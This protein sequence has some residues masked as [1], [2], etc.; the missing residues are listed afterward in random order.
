MNKIAHLLTISLAIILVCDFLGC[1]E[2]TKQNSNSL[3]IGLSSR[4]KSLDPRISTDVSSA[5]VQQLVFNSLVKKDEK[6]NIIPDLAERWEIEDN[7][8]YRFFLRKKVRFHNGKLLT[9]KDVKAT[10]EAI[11]SNE[12]GSLKK[13]AYEK[14]DSIT[15][16]DDYTIVFKTSEVFAPFLINMV[17]SIL[18]EEE[19]NRINP[20]ESIKIIGTGPFKF[21]HWEGDEKL[22]LSAFHDC[23][24]GQPKLDSIV[25]RVIPDDTI[26][27]MELEKGSIDFIQN[28]IPPDALQRIAE[29]DSLQIMSAH[30]TSY[31]Y[32]GFN[33]RLDYPC[34]SQKVRK[35]LALALNRE[36]IITHLLA[37]YASLSASVLPADHWA[38]DQQLKQIPFNPEEAGKLLD[39]AGYPMVNGKRFGLEFKCSQNKQS[40]RLAEVIQAQW[41]EIGID[42]EIRSL[43]WGTFYDNILKGN[44][45]TYVLS[46]VGVT[47]PDIYYSLFSSKSFPPDGRNRGHYQSEVMDSALEKGRNLL[48]EKDRIAAYRAVQEIAEQELP[49][50]NLWHTDNIAVIK[51]GIKGYI[52]YPAGDFDSLRQVYWERIE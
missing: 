10:F 30:G 6:S 37:G 43:E 25:F 29:D 8:T 2:G 38:Y 52:L 3:V 42:L 7:T 46:W 11:R 35:A 28:N 39:E 26:R 16:E 32:L 22:V 45:Q 4:P 1:T 40:R 24:L 21:D 23:Y 41:A 18:P 15:I 36:E 34:K 47:D 14:L 49:Y 12:L 48:N 9:A 44:F 31:Y 51:K 50:I 33:F 27:L 5:R 13:G 17:M 20:N 19:A